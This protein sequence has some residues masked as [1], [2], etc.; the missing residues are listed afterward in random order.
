M[1]LVLLI[2]TQW[3][4]GIKPAVCPSLSLFSPLSLLPSACRSGRFVLTLQS[5]RPTSRQ[6]LKKH[7]DVSVLRSM[8]SSNAPRRLNVSC[9]LSWDLVLHPSSLCQRELLPSMAMMTRKMRRRCRGWRHPWK[10]TVVCSWTVWTQREE[11]SPSLNT[12]SRK[13]VTVYRVTA[14]T[15]W[16]FFIHRLIPKILWVSAKSHILQRIF[17]FCSLYTTLMLKV[18]SGQDE[19]LTAAD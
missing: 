5:G 7:A 15:T 16:T 4:S 11:I 3:Q 1:E 6:S 8:T 14:E 12:S 18:N 9:P 10:E 13:R 19:Q 2:S 17:A